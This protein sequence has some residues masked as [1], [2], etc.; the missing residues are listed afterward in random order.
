M[1]KGYWIAFVS[2]T[3]PEKYAGYQAL[4]PKAFAKFNARFLVRGGDA[5]ILEG[6]DWQRHV[7]IE[8]DSVEQARACF[9]SPEYQEARKEREN[10]CQ[11]DIVIVEGMPD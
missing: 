1:A 6:T 9:N 11:A 4:A 3:D 5:H 2:V 10:A 7:I 8:F